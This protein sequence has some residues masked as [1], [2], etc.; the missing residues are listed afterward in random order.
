[1]KAAVEGGV[2]RG[3]SAGGPRGAPGS[4]IGLTLTPLGAGRRPGTGSVSD[5]VRVQVNSVG[6]GAG[7]SGVTGAPAVNRIRGPH[8][9]RGHGVPE[10]LGSPGPGPR[11]LPSRRPC[12][13]RPPGHDPA[14]AMDDRRIGQRSPRAHTPHTPDSPLTRTA[15]PHRA[16]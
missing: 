4:T 11:N 7:G 14:T 15:T 5:P 3:G 16:R 12:A 10:E 2:Y 13:H 8:G 9:R 1:M 6:G